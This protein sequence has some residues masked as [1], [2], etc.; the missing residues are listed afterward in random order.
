MKHDLTLFDLKVFLNANKSEWWKNYY[1]EMSS[2]LSNFLI[3]NNLLVDIM[4]F[5]DDGNVKLDLTIKQSN[6]TPEGVEL[7]KKAIPNWY[8]SHERGAE[9]SK[10]SILEKGLKKIR[11]SKR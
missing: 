6:L 11:E 9:I 3:D 5:D 4:P 7:F 8:K 2:V 10:I 1:L